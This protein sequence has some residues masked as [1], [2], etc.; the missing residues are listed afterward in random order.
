MTQNPLYRYVDMDGDEL[1]VTADL[2]DGLRV[3]TIRIRSRGMISAVQ[4]PVDGGEDDVLHLLAA[5]RSAAG[6]PPEPT[7]PAPAAG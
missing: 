4:L 1:T 7:T 6:L 2:T 3:A 5:I